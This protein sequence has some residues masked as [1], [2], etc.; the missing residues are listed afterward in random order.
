M[1]ARIS[2]ENLDHSSRHDVVSIIVDLN[3]FLVLRFLDGSF[4]R[5]FDVG[6]TPFNVPAF[7]IIKSVLEANVSCRFDKIKTMKL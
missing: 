2:V 7:C 1:A 4:S 3:C 6:C 5:N